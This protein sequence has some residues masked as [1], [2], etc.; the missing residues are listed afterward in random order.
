MG[1]CHLY[2]N[3]IDAAQLQI[4]REP[5]EFPTLTI[6]QVKDNINDYQ[7]EDFEIHNYQSHD[8]IKVAMVA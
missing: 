6:S 1:N 2:D 7:V 5:F 8:A 3:A 4:T